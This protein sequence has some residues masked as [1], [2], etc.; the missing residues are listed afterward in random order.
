MSGRPPAGRTRDEKGVGEE[1]V[2]SS[3]R[4]LGRRAGGGRSRLDVD[5][6]PSSR[7]RLLTGSSFP[8]VGEIVHVSSPATSQAAPGAPEASVPRA[9]VRS[10]V[11]GT[12]QAR[13]WECSATLHVRQNRH[14]W[15][16]AKEKK[17]TFR[18]SKRP[19]AGAL[20]GLAAEGSPDYFGCPEQTAPM[21]RNASRGTRLVSCTPPSAGK[22]CL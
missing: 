14:D 5:S 9:F 10:G 16:P 20:D 7:P 8:A 22:D 12:E 4:H 17:K 3:S 1:N 13:R 15:V 6:V 11:D 2:V 18:S 21:P 19:E